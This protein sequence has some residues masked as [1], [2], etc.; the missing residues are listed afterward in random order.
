MGI[1]LYC[2]RYGCIPFERPGVLE[3]Y[4]AIRN[5]QANIEPDNEPEFVDL[6]RKL[7][8]KDPKT[9]ITMPEMRV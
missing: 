6:I 5:D 4:D 2:L 3:L 7:L 8:D 9:R 1:S